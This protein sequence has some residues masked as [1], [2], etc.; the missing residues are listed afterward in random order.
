MNSWQVFYGRFFLVLV[1]PAPP[2]LSD[3]PL[4]PVELFS[5]EA[6]EDKF[7]NMENYSGTQQC[8]C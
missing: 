5:A 6:P 3:G 8:M 4:R 7:K 1:P 2:L